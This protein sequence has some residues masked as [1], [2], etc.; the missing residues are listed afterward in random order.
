[1]KWQDLNDKILSSTE[2]CRS[3]TDRSKNDN[4]D[5]AALM[6][7]NTEEPLVLWAFQPGR[8]IDG[9]MRTLPP[10]THEEFVT[11]TRTW[12]EAGTPCPQTR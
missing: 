7:H 8:Q 6:K 4:R 2:I 9:S 11:A 1:M 3:L 5:G 10:V 12:V